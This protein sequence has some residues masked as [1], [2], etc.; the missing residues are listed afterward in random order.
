MVKV[1]RSD[2]VFRLTQPHLR[3]KGLPIFDLEK[4]NCWENLHYALLCLDDEQ[5]DLIINSNVKEE[6]KKKKVKA[7]D[8]ALNNEKL[9]QGQTIDTGDKY[10]NEIEKALAKGDMNVVEELLKNIK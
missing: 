10:L 6:Q 7:E 3:T 5:F 2:P 1:Q 8:M 9:E 4:I